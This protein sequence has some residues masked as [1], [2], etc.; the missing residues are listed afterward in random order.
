MNNES[1]KPNTISALLSTTSSI[2]NSTIVTSTVS[3]I[4]LSTQSSS[5]SLSSQS[6]TSAAASSY[7]SSALSSHQNLD[8]TFSAIAAV[9]NASSHLPA[10]TPP[11]AAVVVAV[12]VSSLAAAI[13]P[14]TP[15]VSIAGS[16]LSEITTTTTS[17]RT[18]PTPV[19]TTKET[20]IANKN[21]KN[22]I[23]SKDIIK[24]S[25]D[26]LPSQSSASA[27]SSA[28]SFKGLNPMS[29]VNTSTVQGA[30]TN[31]TGPTANSVAVDNNQSQHQQTNNIQNSV[32]NSSKTSSADDALLS[33]SETTA[34][35]SSAAT[36]TDPSSPSQTVCNANA[37][38]KIDENSN[39]NEKK[40][41]KDVLS[42]SGEESRLKDWDD[43]KLKELLD[44][45]Y[46]YK[47][48]RD[49]ENKS[50]IFLQLLKKA[51]NEDQ[52]YPFCA[53]TS[54]G[55]RNLSSS[56]TSNSYHHYP[57]SHYH[58]HSNS[59]NRSHH[60]K[61]G[62]SLQDLFEIGLHESQL[63]CDQVCGS[64]IGGN[65]R[66]KRQ[67][68]NSRQ[69]KYS[70][71]VSSRQREGGSLPSNVNATHQLSGIG[72]G[73][74]GH[75]LAFMLQEGTT[76]SGKS[77]KKEQK[78]QTGKPSVTTTI[79][80]AAAASTPE[81]KEATNI[82][83]GV[84]GGVASGFVDASPPVA[85]ASENTTSVNTGGGSF[86]TSG[87]DF[88]IDMGEPMMDIQQQQKILQSKGQ[89][90]TKQ[91]Q[92]F[93]ERL[94]TTGKA[95][96][97]VNLIGSTKGSYFPPTSSHGYVD[98]SI[99]FNTLER[100]GTQNTNPN[101]LPKMDAIF[102]PLDENYKSC[103]SVLGSG[104]GDAGTEKTTD[105]LGKPKTNSIYTK[106]SSPASGS[107]LLGGSTTT[108]N[109]I[110]TLTQRQLD[111][112][113]NALSDLY[114]NS[115]TLG[116][117]TLA[118][119]STVGTTMQINCVS[120]TA[121]N[122]GGAGTGILLTSCGNSVST[123]ATVTIPPHPTSTTVST[124]ATITTYAT[125]PSQAKAKAKKKSQQERNTKTVD[126][127]SVA[128]Y[129]GKDTVEELVR[130]IESGG[131]ASK[132][133]DKKKERKKDKDKHQKLKKSNSL[134]EL[135][136]GAK[137]EVHE[138]KRT[139]ATTESNSVL[140][141]QK[142][143]NAN[144]SGSKQN[145]NN[146]SSTADINKNLESKPNTN[147]NTRKSDRRSWGNEDMKYLDDQQNANDTAMVSE[148]KASSIITNLSGATAAANAN[149]ERKNNKGISSL[150]K[151]EKENKDKI[152]E[153]NDKNL[154]N[155][156]T[157]NSSVQQN[158]NTKMEKPDKNDKIE[159]KSEKTER[160]K[161]YD[162]PPNAVTIIDI[163]PMESSCPETAEFHVVTK[164]KKTK[165]PKVINN[166]EETSVT[167]NRTHNFTIQKSSG[168]QQ[169]STPRNK[170]YQYDGN[171]SQQYQ[172]Q[173]SNNT[174]SGLV[175]TSS[176]SSTQAHHHHQYQQSTEAYNNSDKSR[177]K[178]TSSVPPS[179]KSD[180]SD[181]DSVHSL[182]IESTKANAAKESSQKKMKSNSGAKSGN[183]TLASSKNVPISYA[184]IA[185][186]NKEI[187]DAAAAASSNS[188]TISAVEISPNSIDP[189]K[190]MDNCNIIESLLEDKPIP[191]PTQQ[192]NTMK[193]HKVKKS[194]IKQ[195]FPELA[196]TISYSQSLATL[197]ANT[198]STTHSSHAACGGVSDNTP[199]A[200]S[201]CQANVSQHKTSPSE[202]HPAQIQNPQILQKSKSVEND[203]TT[204]S[205]AAHPV[206]SLSS[207]TSYMTP[208][209]SNNL[210][211]QYPALEKT[212]KRHS[213]ANVA[214]NYS[215]ANHMP[216]STSFNFAAAA[217][218][219]ISEPNMNCN[220]NLALTTSTN[221]HTQMPT[222]SVS[223]GVVI[224]TATCVNANNTPNTITTTNNN[225]KSKEKSP[226]IITQSSSTIDGTIVKKS[227]K[228]RQL[229]QQQMAELGMTTLTNQTK[230]IQTGT[231]T[232]TGKKL[233]RTHLKSSNS[234][235]LAANATQQTN[236]RP[237]VIILND[238]R[239]SS[240]CTGD[241]Q[242]TFG[243]FN[244][245]E[246]K[247]FEDDVVGSTSNNSSIDT[248]KIFESQ[249]DV[250]SE[251]D[252]ARHH[253]S[254]SHSQSHPHQHNQHH[255]TCCD[256]TPKSPVAT[257]FN[258][259]GASCE[260]DM[261][262]N[263]TPDILLNSSVDA[264]SPNTSFVNHTNIGG[265]SGAMSATGSNNQSSDSGIYTD[266][267]K[268]SS[269]SASAS[270]S[271]S[272][273]TS[274]TNCTSNS[275]RQRLNKQ[276]MSSPHLSKDDNGGGGVDNKLNTFLSNTKCT[277]SVHTSMDNLDPPPPPQQLETCNDIETAIIA[278][279]R[280]AAK[281]QQQNVSTTITTTSS[282]ATT[283]QFKNSN[284]SSNSSSFSSS[285]SAATALPYNNNNNNNRKYNENHGI[286]GN[287]TNTTSLYHHQQYA[288]SQ[289]TQCDDVIVDDDDS[290]VNTTPRSR[291]P[292]RPRRISI[293]F[294]PP[295]MATA[296]STQQHN[297]IIIDFIGSAWEEIANSK[298][299]KVYDGQ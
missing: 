239:N 174:A 162:T 297:D 203:A 74:V 96:P 79:A 3:S 212:V 19:P 180:S 91:G 111:E 75:E 154:N 223:S 157:N 151:D 22:N 12:A 53:I 11:K 14:D 258:D 164:K 120:P 60:H 137:M 198:A 37:A 240:G 104:V 204:S 107:S 109:N 280:E 155:P 275:S 116:G 13:I 181:L 80:T 254:H 125:G 179:E 5:S 228:D 185:R 149:K 55:S 167:F 57:N 10:T 186:T 58:S 175:I 135:R 158:E 207:S 161:R 259:S 59:H 290:Y 71:S 50:K 234:L 202:P 286:R 26:S 296:F 187:A 282:A 114:A 56:I 123:S 27:S 267:T 30:A 17:T 1:I 152:S 82:V 166:S 214:M 294:I 196:P 134:E 178:S 148:E 238:D 124:S 121:S 163:V 143:G 34:S 257:Y 18:T 21:T 98:E 33:K 146:S 16:T 182:P 78:R 229:Q 68:H 168:T 87:G 92:S 292:S 159:P 8:A 2:A 38:S 106:I 219:Q 90:S 69:K 44:E 206:L 4:S 251:S 6:V 199:P 66:T 274:S 177:R 249:H 256:G 129:R 115:S 237:A 7:T 171:G 48:P 72:V 241:N 89:D 130:Y 147:T 183:A 117:G 248:D 188:A 153:R 269:S 236:P 47:N 144:N 216:L 84:G 172:Q 209:N 287:S 46:S 93:Y 277:S 230:P 136:S 94:A 119:T 15:I 49:K 246:L 51:E 192:A 28:S 291:S 145:K 169:S 225:R 264:S 35:S 190:A 76:A 260:N 262:N 95:I 221:I 210:D 201:S 40:S 140:M 113:G 39:N 43:S 283:K 232:S 112:N 65:Q 52:S 242:F 299:T 88:I 263:S 222:Q 200:S 284:S 288:V 208:L 195:D 279:A 128:G 29:V 220:K 101:P 122:P 100:N 218:Q 235:P 73:S 97:R 64:G 42:E 272:N 85:K 281:H 54:R 118:A 9:V 160:R 170:Y 233:S 197:N 247:L 244:E 62:G 250:S 150:S 189:S 165:K 41:K 105:I 278:A 86:P 31:A 173:Y 32:T 289:Q 276:Q 67:N 266:K 285:S 298:V 270:G 261:A 127:E 252:D 176:G 226:P 138:L 81:T 83:V 108:N 103:K 139:A 255:D 271:S 131:G 20:T 77:L 61:Q 142:S 25:T 193:L 23:N 126:V 45:A 205:N 295:T 273:S 132:T 253:Y 211:Q 24:K 227:K 293:Q 184:D 141:R 133:G 110:S 102:L 231:T 63:D 70:S 156:I 268:T 224:C 217:K 245:D 194:Q 243:D 265:A 213:S 36:T 99:R 215:T 191:P